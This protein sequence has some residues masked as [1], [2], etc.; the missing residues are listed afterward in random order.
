MPQMQILSQDV[1]HRI[2]LIPCFILLIVL[3]GN[4][5]AFAQD[6]ANPFQDSFRE[7]L[8]EFQSE[9]DGEG[10]EL[11]ETDR[12][13]FTPATTLVGRNRF[14][15]ESS[16]S[17]IDNRATA[18][19]NSFPE[20]LTRYGLSDW[21][22]IRLGWNFEAG[23]GGEISGVE[24]GAEEEIGSFERE[25]NVIYGFK[26]AVSEQ[27]EWWPESAVIIH[28]D[29]PTSGPNTATQFVAG[30]VFGWILPNQWTLDSALRYVAANDEGDHFNQWAP[31]VVLKVPVCERWD[32]HAE[33]FGIF[34]D[35]R[36]NEGNPQY[37]SPGIHYLISP[38][39][40]IGV[41]TGWGLNQDAA[42]FFSNV[43]VGVRF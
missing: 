10:E 23:G 43:G 19:T 12:D 31:S 7:N 39:F 22:E 14:M 26:V 8:Q 17:F 25:T 33:Y 16:Y 6:F 27:E 24:L 21:F 38:E 35:N 36:A 32:V 4:T 18:D 41:R 11:L 40:E 3:L 28:A 30:Y 34:S 1:R 42:N 9:G 29:T 37:F 13:S 5:C 20:L 2:V 15:I